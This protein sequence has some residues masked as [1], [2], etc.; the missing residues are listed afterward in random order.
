MAA[1]NLNCF[2]VALQLS[3]F[4]PVFAE[5]WDLFSAKSVHSKQFVDLM[6]TTKKGCKIGLAT[7]PLYYSYNLQP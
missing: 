4:W 3:A 6:T 7:G 5:K 1:R 2:L